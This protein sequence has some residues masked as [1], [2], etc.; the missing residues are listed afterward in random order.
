MD[1]GCP[2]RAHTFT[3][4]LKPS[5]TFSHPLTP[6]HTISQVMLIHP[7]TGERLGFSVTLALTVVA[8]DIVVAN[9]LPITQDW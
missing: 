8:L 4:L 7:S 6:S 5:H 3:H 2:S 1:A 9:K